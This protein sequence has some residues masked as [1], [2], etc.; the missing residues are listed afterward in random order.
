MWFNK[1]KFPGVIF[2]NKQTGILMPFDAHFLAIVGKGIKGKVYKEGEKAT[3]EEI[4]KAH[5][6]YI[7]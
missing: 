2:W 6:E 3:E 5:A 1:F 4:N 7:E